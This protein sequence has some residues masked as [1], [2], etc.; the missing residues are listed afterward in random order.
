[1]LDPIT[2]YILNEGYILDD[3]TISCDLSKFKSGESNVLLIAGLPAAG[4][5]TL[6]RKLEKTYNAKLF[7]TDWC[8]SEVISIDKRQYKDPEKCYE[9]S[10]KIAMKSNKRY[11]LEGVLIYWTCVQMKNKTLR[12]FFNQCKNTPIIIL[13]SSV[14][15]SAWRG[16][17]R[18]RERLAFEDIFNWYVKKGIK[19]QKAFNLF[20]KERMN[21]PGTE[22][23]K[24]KI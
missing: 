1:M 4:K 10:F 8:L 17:Q 15:K 16:W 3:K 9:D 22:V 7:R 20:R 5:T 12:P 14:M 11:I 6:G 18:E 24:Y 13:G 2:Q 23:R 21:V 19:D